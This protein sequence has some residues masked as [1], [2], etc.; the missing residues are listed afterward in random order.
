MEEL[1]L[2][3]EN[4]LTYLLPRLQKKNGGGKATTD[5][6][7]Q[8]HDF[9]GLSLRTQDRIFKK[10]APLYEEGRS[11]RDIEEKTGIARSTIRKALQEN[12]FAL[13]NPN[14]GNGKDFNSKNRKYSG[15]VPYGWVCFDG[16]LVIDPKEQLVIRQIMKLRQTGAAYNAIAKHL[17]AKKVPTRLNGKWR[18][19]TIKLIINRQKKQNPNGGSNE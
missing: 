5:E 16:K 9:I 19:T 13:R 2:I 3:T 1:D 11:L 8:F 10:C 7:P 15:G 6:P 12:G 14:Q 18:D 17:N 4:R